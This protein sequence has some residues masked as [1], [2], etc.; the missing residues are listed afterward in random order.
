MSDYHTDGEFVN[1]G[2]IGHID[3]GKQQLYALAISLIHSTSQQVIVPDNTTSTNGLPKVKEPEYCSADL[4]QAAPL[5][6]LID[7][8]HSWRGERR[9]KGGKHKFPI[10]R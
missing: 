9:G 2:T 6:P 1:V 3:H 10:R 4:L 7:D 5:K 8:S